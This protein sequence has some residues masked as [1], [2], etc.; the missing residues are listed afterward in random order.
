MAIVKRVLHRS[1]LYRDIMTRSRAKRTLEELA[2]KSDSDDYD[3]SDRPMRSSQHAATKS[4]KKKKVKPLKKRQRQDSDD[5]MESDDVLSDPD[6]LSM[7]DSDV[8]G[9]DDVEKNARG[10]ARR[11]AAR[12]RPMYKEDDSSSQENVVEEEMEEKGDDAK[13][14]QRTKGSTV[15]TLKIGKGTKRQPT[16]EIFHTTRRSTRHNRASSEDIY[17]LTN[18]GRHVLTVERGTR[19]PEAQPYRLPRGPRGLPVKTIEEEENPPH[20]KPDEDEHE[21]SGGGP[22]ASQLEISEGDPQGDFEGFSACY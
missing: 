2:N 6:D 20:D 19:S 15:I 11:R 10:L 5:N 1:P 13:P 21:V 14:S 12:N 18:S 16:P 17:A 22:K 9:D 3:Y 7:Q 4:N 8:L